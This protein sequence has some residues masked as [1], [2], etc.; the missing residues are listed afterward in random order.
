M[1]FTFKYNKFSINDTFNSVELRASKRYINRLFTGADEL[2]VLHRGDGGVI[3]LSL[4]ELITEM[5]KPYNSQTTISRYCKNT[6]AEY[7]I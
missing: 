3:E 4:Q 7:F 6:F 5:N 2:I 1:W